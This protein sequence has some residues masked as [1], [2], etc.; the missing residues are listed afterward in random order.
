[1]QLSRKVRLARRRESAF[2]RSNG[3]AFALSEKG[4]RSAKAGGDQVIMVCS[5]GVPNMNFHGVGFRVC[6]YCGKRMRIIQRGVR[7]DEGGYFELQTFTCVECDIRSEWR[8]N[9][10]GSIRGPRHAVPE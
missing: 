9:T 7:L 10:D 3:T 1:M 6:Q 4:L 2:S 8:V 5:V